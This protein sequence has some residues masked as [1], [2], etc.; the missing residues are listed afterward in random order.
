[1]SNFQ[2]GV[3]AVVVLVSVALVI[4]IVH[5]EKLSSPKNTENFKNFKNFKNVNDFGPSEIGNEKQPFPDP[6][7]GNME[8]SYDSYGPVSHGPKPMA[9]KISDGYM[10]GCKNSRNVHPLNCMDRQN[11]YTGG[12][13]F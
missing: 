13:M 7:R 4:V 8:L 1:M 5:Y 3:L 10:L 6:Q 11:K 9:L 2:N 12:L